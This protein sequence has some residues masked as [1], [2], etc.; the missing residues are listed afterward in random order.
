ME[1]GQCQEVRDQGVH[2]PLRGLERTTPP[3]Q[4]RCVLG[5]D[6][7]PVLCWPFVVSPDMSLSNLE[8]SLTDPVIELPMGAH[9]FKQIQ[10]Y[11]ATCEML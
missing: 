2:D 11:L 6:G 8:F 5:F 3:P 9:Q 7:P 4:Q 10:L 1:E